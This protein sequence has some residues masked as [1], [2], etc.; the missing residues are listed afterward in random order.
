MGFLLVFCSNHS[1]K[2][3]RFETRGI[4]QTDRRIAVALNALSTARRWHRPNELNLR[5]AVSVLRLSKSCRVSLTERATDRTSPIVD[6]LVDNILT[7]N[8]R[9][10][11]RA[12]HSFVSYVD[13]IL[14]IVNEKATILALE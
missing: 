13:N 1:P 11:K 6:D 10:K 9:D 7:D 2:M 14:V 3:Y 12:L 5:A 8:S 4:R